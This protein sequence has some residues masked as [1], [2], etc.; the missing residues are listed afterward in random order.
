VAVAV[1]AGCRDNTVGIAF[2]PAPGD[3]Y[4][5]RIEVH[6]TTVARLGAEPPRRSVA[7]TVFEARHAVI[8]AGPSG[9]TAEV[10]LRERGGRALT[11][12]VRLDRAAQL[13]EVQRIEGLPAE[14][15]GD[16]G[17]SEIFP[18]AVTGPP[19][20]RLA[21]GERWSIDEPVR[22]DAAGPTRL[23]GSG[24]L[25]ELGLDDRRR[26]AKVEQDYRFPVRRRTEEGSTRLHLEGWQATRAS[27]TYAVDD[28]AVVSG[29]ARTRG[30]YR[31][32][33][34]PP[35]GSPGEPVTGTL[36][37]EVRSTTRRVE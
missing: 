21:P 1:L 18:A 11:F 35:D 29:Q 9:T 33:V 27:G 37:V 17:L 19:E 12:S 22:V 28:G 23:V 15:L 34:L 25:V 20:R 5:Y 6:A 16:L 13:T 8:D 36:M 31:L 30:T 26:V 14:A 3:R 10:H 32:T 24:R 2:R 7:D 4:A